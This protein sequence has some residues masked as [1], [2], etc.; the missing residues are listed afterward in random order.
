MT[1]YLIIGA[2]RSGTT[3][4]HLALA[5]HPEVAALRN[6]LKIEP[7]FT[8]GTRI[9]SY[10]QA[11]DPASLA[12]NTC[13][14][15]DALMQS[16]VTATTQ[17]RG[18]KVACAHAAEVELVQQCLLDDGSAWKFITVRR[19]DKLATIGSLKVAQQTN[20]Y[21]IHDKT[22]Q[23]ATP[24]VQLNPLELE[25]AVLNLCEIDKALDG[26]SDK[27]PV[28]DV[29]YEDLM[30]TP[31]SELSRIFDFV[32]V[33]SMEKQSLP[34]KKVLPNPQ[35]YVQNYE[36]ARKIVEDT[37]SAF[38]HGKLTTKSER[39]RSMLRKQRAIQ[40]A[41]HYGGRLRN[42]LGR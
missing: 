11:S 33:Q 24:T 28:V 26:L 35:D 12:A 25:H 14:L 23:Q 37:E 16:E 13:A 15:F 31:H 3:L 22:Q 39:Y 21:H 32:G 40:L 36:A 5:N 4:A 9:F 41:K 10:N 2:K 8:Q 30:A 29:A 6:E 1:R 20:L 42:K 18:A 17:A 38:R 7:F 34:M 27:C 19:R